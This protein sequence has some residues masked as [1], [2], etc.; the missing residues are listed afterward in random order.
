MFLESLTIGMLATN[1]YV[2]AADKRASAVVIDPAGE[3]KKIVSRLHR[4]EL[5]CVG[6][7]C[8]HG[9]VDHVAGAGPLSGAVGAPVYIH[10]AEAGAL[11][12]PRTRLLGLAGGVMA[13][14]PDQV[15]YMDDGDCIEVGDIILEVLHT[16][17]HT[18][19]GVSFY[20]PGY[21][22]C[23]DLIFQ[24]SIGR[25]DL[26]GGSL[27]GLMR[28]VREKVWDMPDDTRILPGHGPETTLGE[29]R[30]HN[31][32]LQGLGSSRSRRL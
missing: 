4:A 8:T 15:I 32:F 25:T 5:E 2:V 7:L 3:T 24:G 13:T 29:E 19:G 10:E 6:I 1:C 28:A 17:G 30:R 11:A 26:R 23:G 14:R 31:P 27:Q 22:F 16:P 20:T 21:L 9:H 12:S 18:P